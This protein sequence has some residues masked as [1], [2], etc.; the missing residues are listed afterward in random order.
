M[1]LKTIWDNSVRRAQ[2]NKAKIEKSK[3]SSKDLWNIKGRNDDYRFQKGEISSEDSEAVWI[4]L[5]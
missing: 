3:Q 1:N 2:Q 4:I 5:K